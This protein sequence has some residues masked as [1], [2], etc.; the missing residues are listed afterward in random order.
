MDPEGKNGTVASAKGDHADE[1]HACGPSD[2]EG[3]VRR[4]TPT[5]STRQWPPDKGG[6]RASSGAVQDGCPS[7][8]ASEATGR[9]GSAAVVELKKSEGE[10][11]QDVKV[12]R[13]G[14]GAQ[15]ARRHC[16][17]CME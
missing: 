7:D 16:R 1:Q 14:R 9:D 2:S 11:M 12:S 6:S 3:Q 15:D 4:A 8:K 13:R 5:Y 10:A 17:Q